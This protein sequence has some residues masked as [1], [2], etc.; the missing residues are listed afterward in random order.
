MQSRAHKNL[1]EIQQ[2]TKKREELENDCEKAKS[3]TQEENERKNKLE[4][5]VGEIFGKL[6]STVQ[7][8][9]LP[10]TEK[11]DQIVQAI[12]RYQKDIEGL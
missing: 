7:A 9:E 11:I 4:Q 1:V 8:K 2:E 10:A 12:D 5:R 3:K 6:P